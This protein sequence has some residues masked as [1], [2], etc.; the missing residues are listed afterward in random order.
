LSKVLGPNGKLLP[1]E[2]EHCKK[3][4]LCI[5][6]ALKDHMADKCPLHNE[7]AHGKVAQID[8]LSKGDNLAHEA[9]LSD[10]PN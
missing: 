9:E 4:G 3:H 5:I 6:C 7:K 10:S 8:P 2:K 1:K